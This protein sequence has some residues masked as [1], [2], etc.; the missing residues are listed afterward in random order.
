VPPPRMEAAA[1]AMNSRRLMMPSNSTWRSGV[2]SDLEADAG[3]LR[4]S[5]WGSEA[6]YL[7]IDSDGRLP[8]HPAEL[9]LLVDD[10]VGERDEDGRN[11]DPLR[12]GGF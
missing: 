1:S 5:G 10:L 3:D 6:N 7:A 4:E 11:S 2:L 12:F 8:R 9:V